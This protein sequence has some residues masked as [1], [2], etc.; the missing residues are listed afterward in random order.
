MTYDILIFQGVESSGEQRV[1][2]A[3]GNPGAFVTGVQKVSQSFLKMLLTESGSM[4]ND[5]KLGT[6]FLSQLRSGFIQDESALQAAFQA[7]VMDVK[8]YVS[9][10]EPNDIPDD[11]KLDSA[12]LVAWDLRPGFFSITVRIV[13]AAGDSRVYT[14]PVDTRGTT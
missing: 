4:N 5:S 7:A 12:T 6:D 2:L 11:E 14:M 9:E 1:D 3:L 10:N 8:N 13:T